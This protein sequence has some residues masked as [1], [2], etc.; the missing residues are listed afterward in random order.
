[1]ASR[2]PRSA[3]LARGARRSAGLTFLGAFCLAAVLLVAAAAL[4]PVAA[5]EVTAQPG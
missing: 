4:V 3:A 1:L 5:L 2:S